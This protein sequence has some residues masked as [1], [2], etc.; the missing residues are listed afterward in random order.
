MIEE[1]KIEKPFIMNKKVAAMIQYH[2]KKEKIVYTIEETSD[3]IIYMI[4]SILRESQTY[5]I[6]YNKH[7]GTWS[8][9]CPAFKFRRR[10]GKEECKHIEFI[11]LLIEDN[12]PIGS[13]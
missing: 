7:L 5:N 11:K 13:M 3:E 9:D 10:L 12:V 6:V 2:L 8:C 1:I 4:K